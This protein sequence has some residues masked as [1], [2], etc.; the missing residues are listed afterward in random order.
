MAG[1]TNKDQVA[2]GGSPAIEVEEAVYDGQK[3]APVEEITPRAI[4]NRFD[5]LRDLTDEEMAKLNK[6]VVKKLDLRLIP[7]IT[8]MYLMAYVFPSTTSYFNPC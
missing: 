7:C 8:I 2:L 1:D 4:Q 3:T 5:L 6:Q